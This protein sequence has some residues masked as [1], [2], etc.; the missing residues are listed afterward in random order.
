MAKRFNGDP[1]RRLGLV[2][3]GVVWMLSGAL[4]AFN[5]PPHDFR[6]AAALPAVGWIT[7]VFGGYVGFKALHSSGSTDRRGP[8]HASGEETSVRDSAKFV[9]IFPLLLACGIWA[10]LDGCHRGLLSL[11]GLGFASLAMSLLG[12]P[13][14]VSLSKWLLRRGR[15]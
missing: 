12:L 9:V 10:V 15:R 11:V 8:R 7:M 5:P 4:M 3:F 2:V 1:V 13:L 14:A 6:R